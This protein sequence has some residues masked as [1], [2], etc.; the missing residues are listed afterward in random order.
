MR[1]HDGPNRSPILGSDDDKFVTGHVNVSR[2]TRCR[3]L[4]L[5]RLAV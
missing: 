1:V 3:Q 4:L 2:Q 5:Q